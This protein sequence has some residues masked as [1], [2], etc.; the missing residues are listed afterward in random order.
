VYYDAE[1]GQG[2]GYKIRE[3][4]FF[5]RIG[6]GEQESFDLAF[7]TKL[8]ESNA[9]PLLNDAVDAC[10]KVMATLPAQQQRSVRTACGF[11]DVRSLGLAS[12]QRCRQIMVVLQRCLVSQ[13]QLEAISQ[14]PHQPHAKRVRLQPRCVFL[15]GDA[16]Y[17]AAHDNASHKT[18]IFRVARF[19]EIKA[20]DKSITVEPRFNL[21]SF[22]GNAWC[23]LC[24]ERD[25]RV[26]ILFR[27]PVIAARVEETVW[28]RTQSLRRRRNG[29]LVFRATVSGLEE[30]TPWVL[31]WGPAAVVLKPAELARRVFDLA[32][33][34]AESYRTSPRNS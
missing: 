14:G 5:P 21:H 11:F 10:G 13:R 17:L 34:T 8:A 9:I 24:G 3:G 33:E 1:H 28:H 15:A 31:R 25:W 6:L 22:L 4:Y 16:W 23:V 30:I 32:V 7:L 12:H 2:G 20:L 26:E 27:D 18:K 29:S 19:R